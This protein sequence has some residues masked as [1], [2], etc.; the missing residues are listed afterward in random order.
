MSTKVY[1]IAVKTGEYQKDGQ[2][3]GRYKNIGCVMKN[4]DGGS[5][6]ILDRTFSGAGLPNP[7]GRDTYIASLFEIK[8]QQQAPPQQQAAPDQA[9]AQAPPA[10]QA[11]PA[12]FDSHDSDVPF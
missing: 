7:E 1:D 10:Q 2:I 4:D 12:G 6:M 5:F 8:D 3:K 11:P 9:R